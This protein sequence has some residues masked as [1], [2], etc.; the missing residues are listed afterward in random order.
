MKHANKGH[1][2]SRKELKHFKD[3]LLRKRKDAMETLEI[4]DNSI[5]NLNEVDDADY[6]SITHHMGDVGSD[7]EEE[8]LNY[9]LKERT[10]KFI[11]EI[12][13]ALKRM[14]NGTYGICA[15][16]GKPISRERLESV[17]HTRYSIEAKKRGLAEDD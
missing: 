17:P 3:L 12:D 8:E 13:E 16:T 14:Q 11:A 4:L 1:Y 15:A 7:V 10:Q 6:S 2:L 5:S 9:Q